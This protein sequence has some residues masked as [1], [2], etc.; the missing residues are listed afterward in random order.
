M[1]PSKTIALGILQAL[2]VIVLVGLGLY[3]IYCI[4]AV[5][6]YLLVSIVLALIANPIVEFLRRRLKFGNTFAVAFTLTLFVFLLVGLISLFIPLIVTQGNKLSLLDAHAIEIRLMAL[7]QQV[8]TYLHQHNMDLDGLIKQSDITSK[9]KFNSITDFLNGII[10]TVS[11]LSIGLVSVFFI[12]FFF[13][14]DKVQFLVGAKYVLPE[15]HQEPILESVDKIRE[16]LSRYFIG[17]IIQLTI[18]CILYLIVL[19]I[20]DV[21]NAFVIAFLCA[22]LNIIP[23][24]GPMIGTGIA[25]VL[26]MLSN[27]NADFSTVTL[28]TTLYVLIGFSIVQMIDN[29]ITSPIIFSK[30]VKSHPLEIFLV[31]LISGILFGIMGMIIA[32]PTFTIVKVIAKTFF[33]E[34]NI[35]RQMTKNL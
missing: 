10:N 12:T 30:S 3:F 25:G 35:V 26:T 34:A 7:Y 4:Q 22:L 21:E 33:P 16:L 5:I 32:V 11:S 8:D 13:L 23:Y 2:A 24:V 28:P 14:K 27:I 15:K 9:L 19:L 20:F 6:V 17:L 31:V 29:N 18:V 1:T